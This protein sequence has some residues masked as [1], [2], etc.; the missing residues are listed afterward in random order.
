MH[1]NA[2]SLSWERLTRETG[3]LRE[4]AR[5][6]CAFDPS[7]A[8]DL[9]QDTV[10][11]ALCAPPSR[12]W[13]VRSWLRGVLR[14]LALSARRARDRRRRRELMA[15]GCDASRDPGELVAEAEL[16]DL[17]LAELRRLNE[18]YRG[19]IWMRY[20]EHLDHA[21]I[22]ARHG[23]AVATVRSWLKRG[24]ALM[25]R[26]VVVKHDRRRHGL[27]AIALLWRRL[28]RTPLAGTAGLA[29]G[30]LVVAMIAAAPRMQPVESAPSFEPSRVAIA[31]DGAKV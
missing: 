22:A 30:L 14:H 8:D 5:Q 15:V 9:V 11:S 3:D 25:P 20:F 2:A 16:I 29:G 7:S 31:T 4:L 21:T 24:L 27:A 10:V 12:S 19:T 17:L 26:R 23:V 1:Q 6:L 13:E 28:M 18:P